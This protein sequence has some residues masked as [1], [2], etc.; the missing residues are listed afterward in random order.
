MCV[1]ANM[2]VRRRASRRISGCFAKRYEDDAPA[3]AQP[4]LIVPGRESSIES[5]TG[6]DLA[7]DVVGTVQIGMNFPPAIVPVLADE[8]VPVP[9]KASAFRRG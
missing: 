3:G 7:D 6:K 8:P 2:L 9:S 4:V 1:V 5:E